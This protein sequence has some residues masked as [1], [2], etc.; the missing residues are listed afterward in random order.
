VLHRSALLILLLQ[1]NLE[2]NPCNATTSYWNVLERNCG[3]R[4]F[5]VIE[6]MVA[7]D[8]VEPPT[9]AFSGLQFA[10]A[11]NQNR[12]ESLTVHHP[13]KLRVNPHP[14]EDMKGPWDSW[15]SCEHFTESLA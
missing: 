11:A 5:Q 1:I 14:I 15:L 3:F 2:T 6:K 7:R 9:P 13:R 12:T 8:G 4:G 10:R